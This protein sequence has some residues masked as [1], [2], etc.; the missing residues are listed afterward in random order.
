MQ[1]RTHPLPLGMQLRN[2]KQLEAINPL[3][4]QPSRINRAVSGLLSDPVN[5]FLAARRVPDS[6][7]DVLR[8]HLIVSSSS[9]SGRANLLRNLL[10]D[11][12]G[13]PSDLLNMR[14]LTAEQTSTLC[15]LYGELRM[16][17]HCRVLC[18]FVGDPWNMRATTH[19]F[20]CV[21]YL[22]GAV[23][24]DEAH[25]PATNVAEHLASLARRFEDGGTVAHAVRESTESGN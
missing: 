3:N 1:F 16:S 25:P 15:R 13:S 9:F 20:A 17:A 12:C 22:Y 8:G 24:D 23:N 14:W 21:C 7:W 18:A 11:L 19:Y 2:G 5:V 4:L 10:F 6:K